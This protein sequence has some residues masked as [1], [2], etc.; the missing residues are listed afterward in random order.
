MSK[1][2]WL[3]TL[4]ESIY[5]TIICVKI[6]T[7][8][9]VIRNISITPSASRLLCLHGDKKSTNG[10]A[11]NHKYNGQLTPGNPV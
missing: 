5:A 11:K 4:S 10:I 7:K 3:V 6:N 9:L 8:T 2:T 1:T